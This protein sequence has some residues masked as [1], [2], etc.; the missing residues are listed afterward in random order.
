MTTLMSEQKW[1]GEFFLPDD[2]E[3]RFFGQVAYS[4][5]QG[6]VLSCR[7]SGHE[8]PSTTQV[9]HGVLE[10]G[11]KCTL[12][13]QFKP[14]RFGSA[15][16]NGMTTRSGKAGFQFLVLGEFLPEDVKI[17]K[18]DFTFNHL[19][20]FFFNTVKPNV[21]YSSKPVYTINTDFGRIEFGH[22][23]TFDGVGLTASVGTLFYSD[24]SAALDDLASALENVEE[25]HPNV[26]FLLRKEFEFR[27]CLK[28]STALTLIDSC[29]KIALLG[30]LFALLLYSPIYPTSINISKRGKDGYPLILPVFPSIMLDARTLEL[31]E[32]ELLHSHLAI[33]SKSI[34]LPD[35]VSSWIANASK[36]STIISSIQYKTGLRNE[37][38]TH[39]EIVLYATQFESISRAERK[40]KI[41]YEY[42]L[43][44]FA[45]DCIVDGLRALFN[46]SELAKIGQGISDLRNEIA[47]VGRPRYWLSR[48]DL[49]ALLDISQYLQLTIIGHSLISLGVPLA[50]VHQYQKKNCPSV[51]VDS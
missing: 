38:S 26:C 36:N 43:Q 42:P 21:K 9:L 41:K 30:N 20:D 44:A 24:D 10:S 4:P 13:G 11:Q 12:I 15:L 27:V 48:F 35:I 5:T 16:Q 23:G 46:T 49:R 34:S 39:G 8:V 14:N 40:S 28:F 18:L 31:C 25:K 17:S 6:V 29:K 19:Q 7:I 47:H 51:R 37:H 3:R 33:N 45:A 1:I 32:R 2:Y 50:V 22:S